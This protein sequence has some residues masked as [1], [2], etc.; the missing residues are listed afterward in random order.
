MSRAVIHLGVHNH[1]V[2]DGKCRELV[3]ETRKLI[4][5]EVDCTLD[6]KISSISLSVSKTFFVSYLFNDS[7]DGTMELLKGE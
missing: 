1:L 6:A 2:A 3:E 5:K 7:S 4:A